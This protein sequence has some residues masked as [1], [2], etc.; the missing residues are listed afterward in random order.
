MRK[1]N[2]VLAEIAGQI[3]EVPGIDR[4]IYKGTQD[5][6]RSA[7]IYRLRFFC[8]PANKP[9][10]RRDALHVVQSGLESANIQIPYDQIDVHSK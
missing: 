6:G 5:F 1:V 8:P 3:A 10:R 7:I 4:C 2:N 9:E